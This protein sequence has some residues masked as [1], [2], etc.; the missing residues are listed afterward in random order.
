MNLKNKIHVFGGSDTMMH[1]Y[2]N[3]SHVSVSD[4]YRIRYFRIF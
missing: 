1:R 3:L 4:T 2:F